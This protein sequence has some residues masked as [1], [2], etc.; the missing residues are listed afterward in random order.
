[1]RLS[2]VCFPAGTKLFYILKSQTSNLN[3]D[4]FM[5]VK[6][7]GQCKVRS[8]SARSGRARRKGHMRARRPLRV[9]TSPPA[10]AVCPGAPETRRGEVVGPLRIWRH[11]WGPF[12][13]GASG[14][15]PSPVAPSPPARRGRLSLPERP[16][17]ASHSQPPKK[18]TRDL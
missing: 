10:R 6:P 9:S 12:L 16:T 14:R 15:R 8:A 13:T 18:R 17:G 2:L 3:C 11:F 1:M 4:N 7:P 5:Y